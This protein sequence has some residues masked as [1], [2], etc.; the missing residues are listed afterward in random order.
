MPR[1]LLTV[2]IRSGG[3]FETRPHIFVS[4]AFFAVTFF[5]SRSGQV[6]TLRFAQGDSLLQT[7]SESVLGN[8]DEHAV[9]IR[10]LKLSEAAL[11]E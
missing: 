7:G 3:G 4:F 9:G 10:H 5:S 11:G 6:K 8:V 2:A 1:K